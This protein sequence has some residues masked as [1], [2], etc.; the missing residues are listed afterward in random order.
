MT[1]MSHRT[2]EARR[3]RM[4]CNNPMQQAVTRA[5]V[6]AT[7]KRC[8]RKPP[9]PGGNGR[10]PTV[11]ELALSQAL[12][13]VVNVIVPTGMK[14][15]LP[16]HY[17]IDVGN[18]ELKIAIEIDGKSHNSIIRRQQ[19]ERKTAYL[20]SIGWTVLRFTNEAVARSLTDCV[21][22]VL[23]TISPSR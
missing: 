12:G 17:K 11:P 1:A 21:R 2:S 8:G 23:S 22:A 19:D 4:R 14:G 5:K 15:P 6:S 20:Q 9:K 3:S 18:P 7:H 16:S 13:W 10:G